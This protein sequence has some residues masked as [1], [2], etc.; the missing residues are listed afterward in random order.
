MNNP[1][2]LTL[3]S[4]MFSPMAKASE[5]W[6]PIPGWERIYEVSTQGRIRSRTRA[7]AARPTGEGQP[8]ER[9]VLGKL[10]S[11]RVRNGVL[12]VNLNRDGRQHQIS[13]RATVLTVFG[14]PC[15][16]NHKPAHIN[17]DPTDCRLTNLTYRPMACLQKVLD[18][19]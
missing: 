6:A 2:L 12:V 4:L 8:T 5:Q 9:V 7:V 15:P 18:R 16:P 11:P 17:G 3:T 13:V 14:A 10:L 1:C 19:G